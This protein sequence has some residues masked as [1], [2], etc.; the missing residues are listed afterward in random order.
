MQREKKGG[1]PPQPPPFWPMFHLGPY[2]HP[3]PPSFHRAGEV[4][5]TPPGNTEEYQACAS[6]QMRFGR[7]EVPTFCSR[8]GLLFPS[9]AKPTTLHAKQKTKSNRTCTHTSHDHHWLSFLRPLTGSCALVSPF[10]PAS[11]YANHNRSTNYLTARPPMQVRTGRK[12]PLG[13]QQ[14]RPAPHDEEGHSPGGK[15]HALGCG[16]AGG[17]VSNSGRGVCHA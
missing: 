8:G 4:L 9:I 15:G 16:G 17:G 6:L 1:A 5:D 2:T 10:S 12:H 14:R 3:Q 13:K 11:R 7:G